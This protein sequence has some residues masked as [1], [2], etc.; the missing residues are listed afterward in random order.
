M[1]SSSFGKA[2]I[3]I[4]LLFFGAGY[5]VAQAQDRLRVLFIG[6]SLTYSN[7]LPAIIASIAA[8]T[9]QKSFEYKTVAFPDFSL[10]D[11]WKQGDARKELTRGTWNYVVLQQGPSSLPES[12]ILLREYVQKFASEIKRA[13]AKPAL[14][15]VWPA[16]SRQRDLERAIESYQLA[17]RDVDALLLPVGDAWRAALNKKA[18]LQL[19]S[20]DNFHP[21]E[22]GSVLAAWVIFKRLYENPRVPMPDRFK[23]GSKT[24]KLEQSDL[25]VLTEAVDQ[26][27]R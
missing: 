15:M 13:G 3:G 27:F 14:Y 8:S 21:S 6:N 7:D 1:R 5:S 11:H 16:L 17:A 24:I 10:E 25:S 12:R 2:V 22:L 20:S 19:Y 26:V 18:Q 23:V 4:A 9:K